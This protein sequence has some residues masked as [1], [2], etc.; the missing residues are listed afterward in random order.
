MGLV[1]L[2]GKGLFFKVGACTGV[3][4]RPHPVGRPSPD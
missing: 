4:R 1:F 2:H 3:E